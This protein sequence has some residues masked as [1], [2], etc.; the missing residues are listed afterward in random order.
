MILK[1]ISKVCLWVWGWTVKGSVG[2]ELSKKLFVILPHTSNWDGPLGIF[3]KLACDMQLNFLAKNSLFRPP[4]G[5]IVKGLGGVP[6][7]RSKNNR[8]VDYCIDLYRSRENFGLVIT[9]E[10]TRSKVNKLRKGFYNIAHQADI[11]LVFVA[12]DYGSKEVRFRRP[13]YTSG[14]YLA[15]MREVLPWYDGVIAKHQEKNS[16]IDLHELHV[17]DAP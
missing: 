12:F 7:D 6:V 8:L 9:P 11:P 14:D 4:F 13:Y 15:D 1:Y 10:A 5:W 2:N 16:L 3:V 17:S